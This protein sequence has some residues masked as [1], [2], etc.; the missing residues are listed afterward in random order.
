MSSDNRDDSQ[1]TRPR[2]ALNPQRIELW[3]GILP[4]Q[5][6]PKVP[7]PTSPVPRTAKMPPP[8][9]RQALRNSYVAQSGH[10]PIPGNRG[11]G[12]PEEPADQFMRVEYSSA[13]VVRYVRELY[14]KGAN[15]PELEKGKQAI[16]MR[17]TQAWNGFIAGFDSCARRFSHVPA[18]WIAASAVAI[19]LASGGVAVHSCIKANDAQQQLEKQKNEIRDLRKQL[20]QEKAKPSPFSSYIP[21]A[22]RNPPQVPA[23]IPQ[24]IARNSL[25]A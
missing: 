4:S 19:A 20:E 3:S 21:K 5:G 10:P 1:K 11:R 12:V 24:K 13:A 9:P 6:V 17:L 7:R 18:R 22:L 14:L 23:G 15:R 25:R 8:I 16:L 2:A